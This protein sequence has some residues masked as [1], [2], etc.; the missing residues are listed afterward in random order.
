MILN[1]DAHY[2]DDDEDI[3]YCHRCY[4]E[5]SL[6]HHYNFKPDPIFYGEESRYFGVELEVD[7]GGE[8][9]SNAPKVLDIANE[10]AW[11]IYCKHDGSLDEGFEIVSHLM[12]LDYHIEHMPWQPVLNKLIEMGYR[13]HQTGTAGLHVHVNRDSLGDTCHEQEETIA[14][15]LYFME[16]HWN[17]L[18]KFSR[19]TLSQ[20]ERWAAFI[21]GLSEDDFCSLTEEQITYYEALFHSPEIFLWN[22]MNLVVLPVYA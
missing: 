22:G 9:P 5:Y 10:S 14:R 1:E 11:H 20:L 7:C 13:S 6:I 8:C 16:K 2:L 15:I 17:E 21:C 4:E 18:L 12:S 3:P 19:R